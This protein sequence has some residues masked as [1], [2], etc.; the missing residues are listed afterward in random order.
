MSPYFSKRARIL[1]FFASL[2]VG[3]AVMVLSVH[4]LSGP[5][6]GPHYDWLLRFRNPPPAAREIVLIDTAEILEA[7]KAAGVLIILT[8]FDASSLIIQVAVPAPGILGGNF[9]GRPESTGEIRAHFDEEYNL[10]G[11]NIRTLFEAIRIGSVPP[12]DLGRYVAELIELAER[13]KERLSSALLREE[14]EGYARFEQASALFGNVRQAGDLRLLR[15]GGGCDTPWYSRVRPDRDGVLRRIAPVLIASDTELSV[16]IEHIVYAALKSRYPE[17]GIERIDG[18]LYLVRSAAHPAGES[19]TEA[20]LR[21]SRNLVIPL[22]ADG[23]ILVEKPVAADTEAFRHLSLSLF[24]QYEETE[25]ELRRLLREAEAAGIYS[26]TDPELSP[27]YLGEYAES[28]KAEILSDSQTDLKEDWLA[29]KKA[30]LEGLRYFLEGPAE[31]ELV[32]GYEEL[33][34]LLE[35]GEEGVSRLQGLRDELI[36]SFTVIRE[37]EAELRKQRENLETALAGSFCIMGPASDDEPNASAILANTL[38]TGRFIEGALMRDTWLW[39]SLALAIFLFCIAAA[40]PFRTLFWGFF[41][42]GVSF[43]VFSGFFIYSAYWIDPLISA[44]SL[45]GGSIF[46]AFIKAL[47]FRSGSRRLRLAYSRHIGKAPLRQLLRIGRPQLRER[48][49]AYSAII[50]V[51]DPSLP[52]R[53]D[54]GD[55]SG[56]AEAVRAF[57]ETAAGFV[58]KAGGI[59]L[60]CEGDTVLL[61]FGSPPERL[62]RRETGH[63]ATAPFNPA[64]AAINFI[65]ELEK[66]NNSITNGKNTAGRNNADSNPA[67]GSNTALWHFGLDCGDCLFAWSELSLY[68]AYGRPVVRSRILS[69]LCSRFNTRIL[70]SESIREKVNLSARKLQTLGG[71]DGEGREAFYELRLHN[72]D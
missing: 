39:P 35:L 32:A 4:I 43:S 50:A 27:F 5:R 2:F 56:G 20:S 3:A 62:A 28:L 57:H 45:L 14:G 12:Q 68:S 72:E 42:S 26:G 17:T 54:R 24:S 69:G 6:L 44:V 21:K 70:I 30:Y 10:L 1:V 18:N 53:I 66:A 25:K 13:G 29:A 16:G 55:P 63:A 23:A 15:A 64:E 8:E 34:A 33:I 9:S 49:K 58:K 38:I 36:R 48:I 65:T 59:F 31:A 52:L 61:C 40:G 41:L 22:N 46:A 67:Q 19:G 51:K 37:K 71:K 60:G 7:D 11:R 47:I